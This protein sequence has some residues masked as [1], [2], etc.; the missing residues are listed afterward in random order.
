MQ[1]LR[2]ALEK[3]ARMQDLYETTQANDDAI[4]N[5]LH[6]VSVP[7]D[8][9]GRLLAQLTPALEKSQAG[10]SSSLDEDAVR[11][12]LSTT[13]DED[14]VQSQ[15]P[16]RGWS[17]RRWLVTGAV[18]SAA[19]IGGLLLLPRLRT[20]PM[21]ASELIGEAPNWVAA[22]DE[23]WNDNVSAAPQDYPFGTYLA[24]KAD[25]WQTC[26]TTL[27]D[28]SIAYRLSSPYNVEKPAV[29]FVTAHPHRVK[30]VT[31]T[32]PVNPLGNTAGKASGLWQEDDR[33][34]VLVVPGSAR[35]YRSCF[36]ANPE[37]ASIDF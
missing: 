26:R 18:A 19:A 31:P 17:R 27:D 6:Q 12:P 23:T 32:P 34:Y 1:E 2:D 33:L 3:D 14:R 8:L 15:M 10:T 11:V 7:A 28:D 16:N 20:P 22:L 36:K 37:F 24:V 35:Q 21:N 9:A 5:A 25:G 13:D 4:R 29:L 30:D